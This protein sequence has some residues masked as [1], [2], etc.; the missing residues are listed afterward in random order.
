MCTLYSC[1]VLFNWCF[2]V[3]PIFDTA[4]AMMEQTPM[5]HMVSSTGNLQRWHQDV[6]HRHSCENI[7][8]HAQPDGSKGITDVGAAGNHSG[9]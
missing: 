8:S 4:Y 2:G 5:W 6:S 9:I 7:A 1:A 3:M